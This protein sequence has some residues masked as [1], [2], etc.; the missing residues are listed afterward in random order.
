MIQ[1]T[2]KLDSDDSS[3]VSA[4]L[5][6]SEPGCSSPQ[7]EGNNFYSV[8]LSVAL[9]WLIKMRMFIYISDSS[10]DF[11]LFVFIA[12][13]RVSTICSARLLRTCWPKPAYQLEFCW[14]VVPPAGGL[15]AGANYKGSLNPFIVKYLITRVNQ[16]LMQ[17]CMKFLRKLD[18]F[19]T[20]QITVVEIVPGFFV[21]LTISWSVF[22]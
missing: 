2:E 22:T 3:L 19:C 12:H 5:N 15:N 6:N 20:Y 11:S 8:E 9:E 16:L 13:C 4:N 7:D 1:H 14:H 10:V 18:Y 17:L 21:H